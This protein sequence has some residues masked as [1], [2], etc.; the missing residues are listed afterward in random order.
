VA[1]S[2]ASITIERPAADVFPWLVDPEK[3]LQWVTGLRS[4]EPLDE[5]RFREVVQ[6][7]GQRVEATATIA[8]REP[9]HTLDVTMTGRGFE[10]RAEHRL[11]EEEGRTRLTSSFDVKLGG[12]GRFAG[13]IVGRQMQR[14]VEQSLARLKDVLESETPGPDDAEQEPGGEQ[15]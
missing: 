8:R 1:R 4:S 11:S 7:Y 15:D 14:S 2:Q 6:E 9:P 12:L 13:G 10:A 3:R 5:T